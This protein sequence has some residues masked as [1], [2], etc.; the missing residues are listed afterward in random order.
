[1]DQVTEHFHSNQKTPVKSPEEKKKRKRINYGIFW[2]I[3]KSASPH[4]IFY[5]TLLPRLVQVSLLWY[6]LLLVP[7]WI[8]FE[9]SLY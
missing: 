4:I 8:V 3:V 5:F 1:M 9:K 7:L 2:F 6:H